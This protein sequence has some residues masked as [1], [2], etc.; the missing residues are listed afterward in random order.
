M[1]LVRVLLRCRGRCGLEDPYRESLPVQHTTP[2]HSCML[3]VRSPVYCAHHWLRR[4]TRACACQVCANVRAGR[5]RCSTTFPC[6]RIRFRAAQLLNFICT[7]T[8]LNTPVTLI[9]FNKYDAYN[10][11]VHTQAMHFLT[12]INLNVH[13]M[14]QGSSTGV[15]VHI[16]N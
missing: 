4:H 16:H 8:N 2:T 15:T 10:A 7:S 9:K 1:L 6:K 12:R 3:P 5:R 13:S 14:V 11:S